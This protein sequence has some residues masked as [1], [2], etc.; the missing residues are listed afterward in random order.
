MGSAPALEGILHRPLAGPLFVLALAVLLT[1]A[2][3]DS[4][5]R[6]RVTGDPQGK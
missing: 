3:V 4:L 1:G 5:I 6:E 2:L